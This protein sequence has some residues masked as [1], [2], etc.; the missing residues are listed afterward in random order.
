[1]GRHSIDPDGHF[2]VSRVAVRE[3]V[4]LPPPVGDMA[5]LPGVCL[6]ATVM[7]QAVAEAH[8]R[9]IPRLSKHC[10]LIRRWSGAHPPVRRVDLRLD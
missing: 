2:P 8:C 5:K 7:D 4:A 1:M 10:R 6:T 3:V 9:A